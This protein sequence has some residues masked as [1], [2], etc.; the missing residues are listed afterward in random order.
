MERLDPKMTMRTWWIL[1]GVAGV[2]LALPATATV[3]EWSAVGTV[4]TVG[5]TTSLLPLPAA[6][7]DEFELRFSYDDAATDL[8]PDPD[9]G[10][11][12]ILSLRVTIAGSS[13][14]WID[15]GSGMGAIQIYANSVDQNHWGVSGC[16]GACDPDYD[17]A[18]LNFY[19][20]QDTILSDALTPPPDA[21]GASL[22]EFGLFSSTFGSPEESFVDVTLEA[23][24]PEPAAALSLMAGILTLGAVR[25]ARRL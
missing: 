2:A 15:A 7:G 25:S 3:R 20:P 23:V 10:A 1:L 14:D 17:E 6:L 21:T 13:L 4:G 16:L 24:V 18:R 11:Y 8:L 12:P 5:G 19:F 9:R 22:V